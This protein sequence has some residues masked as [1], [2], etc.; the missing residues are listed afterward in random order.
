M[1]RLA[2]LL[3][4]GFAL[5]AQ[6]ASMR[7]TDIRDGSLYLQADRPDTVTVRWVPAWQA[8]ANE[9]HIY[10]I[11]GQGKLEGERLIAASE[12][13]GTQSWPLAPGAASYRLEIPGY[14]FRRYKVEHD[15]HTVALFEP[16]KV[17]FSAETHDGDELYFK[18]A[19]GEHAVLAGKF[20]GGV[21]A[22]QAQR[23]SD[24]QQLS[25][26][27]KPYRAYWQ[28]DQVA[29]PVAQTE[30]IWRL[31]LQGSGKAAFWLDGTANLFA[32]NPQQLKPLR[33][34]D[35]Q[36]R[37]TLH[38]EIL[39]KTPNLGVALPYV[40]PPASSYALLDALK[41]KAA[42]YYSFVDITAK[43]PH[44]E[45]AF[46]QVYQDRFGITQDITLLAGSQRQADL[47]ADTLS[48]S[49]LDA[50]LAST[51]AL[52]G[53][54]THYIGFAD[55]PNLN[56][57]SYANYQSIFNS[58]AR[59]VRSNPAN[60]RA[61]IRIAMPASARL[62]NGPFADNAA[63][64]RGIDWARR[65]LAESGDK[66]DALAWHEWMI[67][68]LLAT[69]VYRDSVRRAAELVGLDAQGRPR[70]ALL[71]D[72]TN[73]SSGSSLSPYDQET[74]YAALWW[75]SVVINSSQDGLL[76][77][78]NWF[79]AAD[80]PNYPKGMLRVLGDDHFEL[81]PV[82]LAQQFIQEHWLGSVMGL[83]NDAFEVDVLA[84]AADLQRSLLGVN[85]G[86]R[87]QRV[88]LSGAACPLNKGSLRY[89][90]AD[91]RSRDAPYR[92]QDG[93]VSFELPGQTLFALSW[94]AS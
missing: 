73:M 40:M 39:G 90:G 14:S 47:R 12:A 16:A 91:N 93:R 51:R 50:W 53:N 88:D 82:G 94:R 28:F 36:T 69:R 38:K 76:E 26:A 83:E 85:K 61:G 80:E 71:L 54:G 2:L 70:K 78:L 6:A 7:W 49:G 75:A 43:N 9:E 45:D 67:R 42:S 30:Q 22:L 52:G 62:V 35:G 64:K 33:E 57:P 44:Y 13:R 59:Q 23:V 56:Y 21:G 66:V 92:C 72:Q 79:Q 4:L 41:A 86:T 46:R 32:Q 48:N 11:D 84:M 17:H 5:D 8:D 3:G 18:V 63:D 89:F 74:H 68:D 20:H 65:L 15:E 29:L 81:K 10:L 24:G 25:L 55:E 1:K 60:A 77:M 58:M 34:D 27:L 19:P 31:R 37:L 87:L